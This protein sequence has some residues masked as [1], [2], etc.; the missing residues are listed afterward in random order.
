MADALARCRPSPRYLGAS[1]LNESSP[2]GS[3]GV[4][5]LGNVL[6]PQQAVEVRYFLLGKLVK[7]DYRPETGEF[8]PLSE[9]RHADSH[10]AYHEP[11]DVVTAP[12][13]LALANQPTILAQVERYLGCCPTISYLAAWWSYPTNFGPQ[14]AEKFHRDV[15]DWRFVKLFVY[16]TDVEDN[17]GPHIYVKESV[18]NPALTAIRRYEDAEVEASMGKE[19]IISNV[20][21]SGIG[22]LENTFGLHKGQPVKSGA[23]LMFQ[24]VYSLLPL[25]YGPSKPVLQG[26]E[27]SQF[28]GVRLD[29]FV[30]RVYL[31]DIK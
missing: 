2:L 17:S 13:L 15:D 26:L 11:F 21:A 10:V 8:L 30:N 22:F 12:H 29:S 4:I 28:S 20:G 16:L 27:G 7:D 9:K 19:N 5:H 24:A 31:A 25:P 3:A 6:T 1:D 18:L 14:Q 23:R